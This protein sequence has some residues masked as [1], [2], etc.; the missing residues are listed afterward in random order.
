MCLVS[1]TKRQIQFIVLT[2]F[3]LFQLSKKMVLARNWDWHCKSK[4]TQN[5]K[6]FGPRNENENRVKG[7]FVN[8]QGSA[9]RLAD[10]RVHLGRDMFVGSSFQFGNPPWNLVCRHIQL[11]AFDADGIKFQVRSSARG[12]R[13]TRPLCHCFV[14]SG[15]SRRTNFAYKQKLIYGEKRKANIFENC[16]CQQ[17]NKA[18]N[19]GDKQRSP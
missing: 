18:K 1:V 14:I 3:V 15:S 4:F 17:I 5:T 6:Q 9:S 2:V 13:K 16:M 10:D 7:S 19:F 12:R 11:S 8:A